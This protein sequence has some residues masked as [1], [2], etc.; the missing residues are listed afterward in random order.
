MKDREKTLTERGIEN[1]NE[2]RATEL[3]GRAKDVV[4][5]ATGD[6]SLEAEGKMD[7]MKGKIQDKFGEAQRETDKRT[8]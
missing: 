6:K 7:R 5:S 4:G 3:K 8:R 2:G 1:Q